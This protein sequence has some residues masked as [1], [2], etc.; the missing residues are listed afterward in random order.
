MDVLVS[1]VGT[2]PPWGLLFAD[3]LALCAESRIDVE[4]LEKWRK[5]LEE[6]GPIITKQGENQV[7]E[8]QKMPRSDTCISVMKTITNRRIIELF[9]LKHTSRRRM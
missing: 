6:N 9:G 4:E 7:P 8:A 2:H 5:V 3:D 1:E